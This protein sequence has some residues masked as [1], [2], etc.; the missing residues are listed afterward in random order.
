[1]APLSFSAAG[2]FVHG[3]LQGCLGKHL[4]AEL[5][6]SG[7]PARLGTPRTRAAVP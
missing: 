4:P 6:N 7:K 2:D 1:M 5:F 3:V